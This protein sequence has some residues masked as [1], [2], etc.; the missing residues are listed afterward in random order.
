MATV[1]QQL[2]E[3]QVFLPGVEANREVIRL[4]RGRGAWGPWTYDSSE[5][6][7]SPGGYGV[8]PRPGRPTEGILPPLC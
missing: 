1:H 3:L 5:L 4:V 7:L 8:S 2:P 6:L